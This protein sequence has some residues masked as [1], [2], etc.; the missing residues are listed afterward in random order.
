MSFGRYLRGKW[1]AILVFVLLSLFQFIFLHVVTKTYYSGIFICGAFLL[2]FALVLGFDYMKKRRYYNYVQE[3][4]ESIKQKTLLGQMIPATDFPEGEFLEE[5]VT[6][7][8]KYMNDEIQKYKLVSREYREYIE[9]W[10]HEVKTPIAASKLLME[11]HPYEKGDSL[12]EEISKIENYVEQAL[13]YARSNSVEKD[14]MVKGCSLMELVAPVLRKNRRAFIL[15]G[16]GLEMEELEGEVFTDEKWSQFILEQII[17]NAIKYHSEN[18]GIRIYARA[19]KNNVELT[20]EDNGIGIAAEDLPRVYEKGFTGK[21]GRQYQ[22]ATGMGLYLVKKLC[23][24]LNH[25]I[26]IE[27]TKGKGTKVTL[28]FPTSEVD[29][30]R[31]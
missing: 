7:M 17:G 22:K 28:I 14:Y 16:I 9:L 29:F 1:L 10:I 20:V 24:K 4:L 27:S 6:V 11:N 26:H 13:Y 21:T 18:P 5:I 31:K 12:S 25:G 23:D 19:T 8:G 15:E 30:L 3:T 2:G